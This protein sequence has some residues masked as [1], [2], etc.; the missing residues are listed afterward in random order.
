[1]CIQE[2]K[3]TVREIFIADFSMLFWF[4]EVLSSEKLLFKTQ[5]ILFPFA[6]EGGF[7]NCCFLRSCM[8]W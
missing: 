7:G 3:N 1:M 5:N 2:A 8:S 4:F 6:D